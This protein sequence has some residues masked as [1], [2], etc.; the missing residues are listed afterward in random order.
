MWS[1]G[2]YYSQVLSFF[3]NAVILTILVSIYKSCYLQFT[4]FFLFSNHFSTLSTFF[5]GHVTGCKTFPLEPPKVMMMM[6]MI[7]NKIIII[8]ITLTTLMFT[9]PGIAAT[10][11][12]WGL[13]F[14]IKEKDTNKKVI[15]NEQP[16]PSWND[17]RKRPPT[18][19]KW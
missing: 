13:S 10:T 3:T 8:M 6:T 12:A 18:T 11:V 2:V 15:Y 14:G 17:S 16:G 9:Q 5:L 1:I 7:T 19:R 4:Y